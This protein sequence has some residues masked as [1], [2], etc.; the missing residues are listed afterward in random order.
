MKTK[1]NISAN[2]D[3]ILSGIR[4]KYKL[5]PNILCRYAILLSLRNEESPKISN[6]NSGREFNRITLTGNDDLIIRELIKMHNEDFISDDDYMDIFL[7][8]HLERGLIM[9]SNNILQ[10]KSFDN[11]IMQ[12]IMNGELA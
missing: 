3:Q 11:Y 6:D 7:K 10:A 4:S 9:L 1:I 2:A 12:L 5:R 8:A